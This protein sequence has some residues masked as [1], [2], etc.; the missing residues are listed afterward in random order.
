MHAINILSSNQSTHRHTRPCKIS[1]NS[2]RQTFITQI[3]RCKYTQTSY[4]HNTS[5][6]KPKKQRTYDIR[7]TKRKQERTTNQHKYIHRA[8][9]FQRILN[10]MLLR[11]IDY[12]KVLTRMVCSQFFPLYPRTSSSVTV[13]SSLS[14]NFLTYFSLLVILVPSL[15]QG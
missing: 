4:T 14:P 2:A 15:L 6:S 5:T 7:R 13:I 3:A 11:S 12:Y 8:N 10:S 9:Y 1:H